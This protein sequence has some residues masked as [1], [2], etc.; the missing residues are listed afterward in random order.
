MDTAA[1]HQPTNPVR[2]VT[3]ASL[4]DG[5]DASINIMRRILQVQGAEVIHLGHN[6]SVDDVV[7]AA[8]QED[9]QGIA[10]SSYQGGHVEYFKYMIDQ[11][12][13]RGGENI[14]V[15]GGGGGVIVPNGIVATTQN[16]YVKP[17]VFNGMPGFAIHAA[18]GTPMAVAQD[19]DVAMA[20]IAQHEM[21]PVS[22]H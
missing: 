22:V 15:F 13:S 18:D 3:A 10:V 12:R 20:A 8:V 6:R 2:F 16:A 21:V 17:V 7:R 1:L 19:R 14:Q 4:F 11:L 5:H 9:V